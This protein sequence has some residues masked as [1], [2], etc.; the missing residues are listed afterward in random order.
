MQL[1]TVHVK[2]RQWLTDRI[3]EIRFDRPSGFDFRPGQKIAFVFEQNSR[4]YTLLGPAHGPELSICVRHVAGGHFSPRL[5]AA[6]PGDVFQVTAPSGFFTFKPSPRPA[7][8]VATGTGVAPF[9]AFE[10]AGVRDFHLLHGVRT[11]ENLIYG[12]EL[13]A[14][15]R[16]YVPCLSQPVAAGGS[17]V[18]FTGR[19]DAWLAT[20]L[21][22]GGYDFYL[23]G[24]G[25]MIRDVMRL[26]DERF[27]SSHV[28]TETFF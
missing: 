4:D 19:V 15:A 8:F 18:H 12:P 27:H 21:P 2:G 1:Y 3:F 6:A 23:C 22:S 20:R 13:A 9:V 17:T 24:N 7:V 28:F 26:I 5:A 10:R 11:A 25:D 16:A 14:A